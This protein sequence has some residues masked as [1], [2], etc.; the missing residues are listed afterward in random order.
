[1]AK[2]CRVPSRPND[3]AADKATEHARFSNIEL[4]Q[5][6]GEIYGLCKDQ[7]GCRFLQKQLEDRDPNHIQMIF[8]ETKDH[9]IELMTGECSVLVR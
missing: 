2:V 3:V 8:A 1:M 7:H 9:V 6:K 4:D 5:I